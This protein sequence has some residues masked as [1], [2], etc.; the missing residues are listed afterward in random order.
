MQPIARA[1]KWKNQII[2]QL[3]LCLIFDQVYTYFSNF[4][5]SISV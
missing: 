2:D 4:F 5:P 3:A 1:A